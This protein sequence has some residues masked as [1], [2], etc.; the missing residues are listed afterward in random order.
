MMSTSPCAG[1]AWWP[2]NFLLVRQVL[3]NLLKNTRFSLQNCQKKLLKPPGSSFQNEKNVLQ[4]SESFLNILGLLYKIE[5]YLLKVA[6]K[7]P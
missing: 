4:N 5:K 3:N 1:A 2:K 7:P 6:E